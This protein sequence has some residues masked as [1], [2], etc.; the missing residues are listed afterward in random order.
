MQ[1][2]KLLV[3][4]PYQNLISTL[5]IERAAS[6]CHVHQYQL[7]I[8][9]FE[10]EEHTH[11]QFFFKKM[12]ILLVLGT[13]ISTTYQTSR[14]SLKIFVNALLG[15]MHICQIPTLA[16]AYIYVS[17]MP[18]S[19]LYTNTLLLLTLPLFITASVNNICLEIWTLGL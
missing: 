18:V 2:L 10:N 5:L 4:Q 9:A 14:I 3:Q 12:I 19:G 16:N 6:I 17:L 8:L 11:A 7:Q 1:V 15:D 13:Q